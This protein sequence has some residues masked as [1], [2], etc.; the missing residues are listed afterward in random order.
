MQ[1]TSLL[2]P[3][4]LGPLSSPLTRALPS[5]CHL[6]SR[7]LQVVAAAGRAVS[8]RS[9]TSLARFLH[10]TV[11]SGIALLQAPMPSRLSLRGPAGTSACPPRPLVPSPN[12]IG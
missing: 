4:A 9:A 8:P 5:A 11:F 10:H 3:L 12:L 2:L 7:I 6:S 1:I